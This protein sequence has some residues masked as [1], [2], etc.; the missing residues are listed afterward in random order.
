MCIFTLK[1]IKTSGVICTPYDCLTGS[2]AFMQ[3]FYLVLLVGMVLT[4][5]HIMETNLVNVD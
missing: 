3:Q 1:D 5:M 4:L 2:I